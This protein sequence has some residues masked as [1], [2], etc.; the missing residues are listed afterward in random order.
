MDS[1]RLRVE[2]SWGTDK[3]DKGYYSLSTAY[4][5]EF[6]YLIAVHK[7]DIPAS[8]GVNVEELL[9]VSPVVLP[10]WDPMGALAE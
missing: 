6:V 8:A 1:L 4:F 3:A 2:N 5:H 10:Y 9:T 7:D